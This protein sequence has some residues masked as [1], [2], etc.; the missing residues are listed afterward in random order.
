LAEG[1]LKEASESYNRLQ[2]NAGFEEQGKSE[3]GQFKQEL[4]LA[5]ARNIMTNAYLNASKTWATSQAETAMPAQPMQMQQQAAEQ[6]WDKLQQAQEVA[7]TKV[8]P[9]RVN[10]PT[11]GVRHSFSQVLQTEERKPMTIQFVASSTRAMG[12]PMRIGL[13]VAALVLLWIVVSVAL[14]RSRTT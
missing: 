14:S 5:Q 12:W 10:L 11:H 1:N 8:K 4:R 7:A 6:Q 2:V 9:L 3:I 13:S